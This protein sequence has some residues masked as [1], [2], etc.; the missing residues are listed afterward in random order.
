MTRY[1][2]DPGIT[3]DGEPPDPGLPADGGAG[4]GALPDPR[5]IPP[6]LRSGLLTPREEQRLQQKELQRA[7][8]RPDV[9]TTADARR[10]VEEQ[11]RRRRGEDRRNRDAFAIAPTVGSETGGP[12][13]GTPA[14]EFVGPPL[15]SARSARSSARLTRRTASSSGISYRSVST[16]SRNSAR[17]AGS[18]RS[19]SRACRHASRWLRCSKTRSSC[20]TS[21]SLSRSG[22]PCATPPAPAARTYAPVTTASVV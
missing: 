8:D 4:G 9:Q 10:A 3:P 22:A 11:R 6:A 1:R 20:A 19:T 21:R 13:G 17:T 12:I 14:P 16:W 15:V 2:H 7:L 5:R 18:V